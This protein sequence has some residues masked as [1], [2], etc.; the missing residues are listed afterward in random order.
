MYFRK[1][2]PRTTCLYSAASIWPRRASAAFQRISARARSVLL[3][4]LVGHQGSVS[5]SFVAPHSAEFFERC[6]G[7]LTRRIT[8]GADWRGTCESTAR[9]CARHGRGIRGASPLGTLTE[10]TPHQ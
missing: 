1:S 10:G 9:E 6:S 5:V 7:G 8:C 3:V 2:R 4:S